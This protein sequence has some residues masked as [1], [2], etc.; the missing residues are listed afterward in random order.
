MHMRRRY[1]NC[2]S[3]RRCAVL[4]K[5]CAGGSTP[6]SLGWDCGVRGTPEGHRGKRGPLSCRLPSSPG[7]MIQGGGLILQ[8]GGSGAYRRPYG[9]LRMKKV[10][11]PL[12]AS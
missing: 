11:V 3:T 10:R 12:S 4:G 8:G 1:A 2:L 6:P 9:P 5:L 7:G